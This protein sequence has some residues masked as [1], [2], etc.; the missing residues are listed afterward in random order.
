MANFIRS[1]KSGNDWTD[2]ELL[3]YN[4]DVVIKSDKEFFGEVPEKLPEGISHQLLEYDFE[5]EKPEKDEELLIYMDLASQGSENVVHSFT[6]EL[7]RTS[8]YRKK[9]RIINTGENMNLVVCAENRTTRTDV[10]ILRPERSIVLLVQEDRMWIDLKY[11]EPQVIAEAIAAFQRNN[12]IRRKKIDRMMIP[13]IV[14]KGT[15]PRFYLVPVTKELNECV[16]TGQ[17]PSNTTEVLIHTPKVSK[18][19]IGA[20]R[21]KENRK[22][23]LQ[24]YE[25]FKQF[26][27]NL[28]NL[29]MTPDIEIS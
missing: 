8:G 13:C 23:I 11:P 22:K 3:A 4:I 7:L 12:R 26:V 18:R 15:L 16:I 17:Y 29:L 25:S 10:S 20:M 2:N 24:C 21:G 19:D 5:K 27:D 9:G 6:Q 14:M 1:P 28:E